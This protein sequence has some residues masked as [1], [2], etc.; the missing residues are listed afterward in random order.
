[1][2]ALELAEKLEEAE[3]TRAISRREPVGVEFF[4]TATE[5]RRLAE[6]NAELVKA[7]EYWVPAFE[8]L[9]GQHD[10]VCMGHREKWH[11]AKAL[12]AK[13]KEQQ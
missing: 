2:K 9:Q 4:A 11:A 6:V 3:L 7:I 12:I 5:L 10:V 1:M 13:A 8:P